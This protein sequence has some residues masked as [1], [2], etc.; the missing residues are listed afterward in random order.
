MGCYANHVSM[1]KEEWLKK[2]GVGVENIKWEDVPEGHLPVVLVF[3]SAFTAAGI[4]YCKSELRLFTNPEDNR[5]KKF[6]IVPIDALREVSPVDDYLAR[7]R[8]A[9]AES[10]A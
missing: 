4:A 9:R 1:D 10:A 7:E 6:F 2:N 5:P 3:N 8:R